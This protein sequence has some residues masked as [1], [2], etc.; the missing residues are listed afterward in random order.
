MPSAPKIR[1]C[2]YIVLAS[3][4]TVLAFDFAYNWM[5]GGEANRAQFLLI[6]GGLGT[7]AALLWMRYA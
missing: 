7:S 3:L 6:F 5:T 1:T 4:F 2:I